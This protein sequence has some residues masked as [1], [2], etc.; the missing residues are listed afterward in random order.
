M[1]M[2][3]LRNA[4]RILLPVALAFSVYLLLRGHNEP[5]GGF[6]GG[7]V[8]SAGLTVHGAA[9]GGERLLRTLRLAPAT[10]GAIGLV[11]ALVSGL[12]G[13]LLGQPFLTHQWGMGPAGLAL[14]TTLVFD[15][16]VYLAVLGAVTGFVAHYLPER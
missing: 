4:S 14:G 16:G 13:L 8:A 3:I 11:L 1:N 12:P 7:L 10:Y 9:L 15:L 2:L 6:V 5:G